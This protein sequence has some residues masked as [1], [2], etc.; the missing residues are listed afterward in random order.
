MRNTWAIYREV[1][2]NSSKGEL[3]PDVIFLRHLG[4][5]KAR[6]LRAWRFMISPRPIS[7]LVR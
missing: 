1:G 3:I 2:D 7:L 5:I 4:I 6:D